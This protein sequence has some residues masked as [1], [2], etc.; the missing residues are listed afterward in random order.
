MEAGRDMQSVQSY[1]LCFQFSIATQAA[2][3]GSQGSDLRVSVQD[4]KDLGGRVLR[5]CADVKRCEACLG[6]DSGLGCGTSGLQEMAEKLRE[7]QI[8]ENTQQDLESRLI[9]VRTP[10][11]ASHSWEY[12]EK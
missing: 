5:K 1:Q 6:Y 9:L 10:L 12:G 11:T 2:Q 7:F 8:S 4:A 3:R